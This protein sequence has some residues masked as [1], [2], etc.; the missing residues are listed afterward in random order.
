M[1]HEVPTMVPH[2]DVYVY[3]PECN[4]DFCILAT[5][6]MSDLR[7]TM[8]K[9]A[10]GRPCRV[11]LILYCREPLEGIRGSVGRFSGIKTPFGLRPKQK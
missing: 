2:I 11:E 5:G 7:M 9:N 4:P 10:A 3:K 8:P 1:Y 6:G